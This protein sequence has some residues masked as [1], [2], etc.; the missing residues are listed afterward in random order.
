[1]LTRDN[2]QNWQLCEGQPG[3]RIQS[4]FFS[5]AGAAGTAVAAALLLLVGTPSN[6]LT[7]SSGSASAENL[8]Q[9]MQMLPTTYVPSSYARGALHHI[10]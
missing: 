4:S 7:S 8:D 6:A 3:L 5:S 9:Q 2:L 1:M 10:Q